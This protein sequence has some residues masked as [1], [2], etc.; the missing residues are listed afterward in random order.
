MKLVFKNVGQGDSII[1]HWIEE[2]VNKFI[3]ID[4]NEFQGRVPSWE[5]ISSFDNPEVEIILLSHPHTD[6]FSGMS[7]LLDQIK[8]KDVP[9]KYIL[10]TCSNVPDYLRGSVKGHVAINDLSIL[11]KK[12]RDFRDKMNCNLASIDGDSPFS[13]MRFN[14][15]SYRLTIL[16][17]TSIE[18]DR[19]AKQAFRGE[20]FESKSNNANANYLSSTIIIE[21]EHEYC[22]LTSDTMKY[23]LVRLDR[24]QKLELEKILTVGQAPHHGSKGNHNNTFWRKRKLSNKSHIAVSTGPNTYGHPHPEVVR[25]FAHQPSQLHITGNLA[26][27]QHSSYLNIFSTSRYSVPV[28]KT[29]LVFNLK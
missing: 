10:H 4:C 15:E 2:E 25:F 3:L 8:E 27:E 6:H 18:Y 21:S 24:K 28:D 16:S 5:Y 22:L 19:F 14:R 12:F 26:T 1:I 20:S 29:D 11:F 7:Q 23:S 9:L 17:P 13:T